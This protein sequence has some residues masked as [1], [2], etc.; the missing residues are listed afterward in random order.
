VV[1]PQRIVFTFAW[2]DA[3]GN[4]GHATL[5]TVTLAE[6]GAKTKLTLHQAIFETVTT[7]DGQRTGWV[8]CLERFANYLANT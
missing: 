1:A 8:S 7:R 6:Q 5:V 2:E 4:P 3:A